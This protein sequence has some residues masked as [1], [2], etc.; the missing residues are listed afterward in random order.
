[1]GLVLHRGADVWN[2]AFVYK[3]LVG[4][5]LCTVALHSTSVQLWDG[6]NQRAVST[7]GCAALIAEGA[8]DV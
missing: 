4:R 6:T 7:V 1:M 8:F 2:G 5:C 3:A